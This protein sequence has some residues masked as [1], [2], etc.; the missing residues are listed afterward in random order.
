MPPS[1]FD[2]KKKSRDR[3]ERERQQSVISLSSDLAGMLQ[4]SR[5][6]AKAD[7]F[8]L[9]CQ[10]MIQDGSLQ[11]Q[12]TPEIRKSKQQRRQDEV[13]TLYC[14]THRTGSQ[15]DSSRID[16]RSPR[17]SQHIGTQTQRVSKEKAKCCRKSSKASLHIC[18]HAFS[19]SI[20]FQKK[21][22]SGRCRK[23]CWYRQSTDQSC[24][25]SPHRFRVSKP[26][27]TGQKKQTLQITQRTRAAP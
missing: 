20:P 18:V 1:T 4:F 6:N 15:K 10:Y 26:K 21:N 13:N 16:I 5:A 12:R 27:L 25:L 23:V 3:R 9:P 22:K 8:H 2:K 19:Q 7:R 11:G 17:K 24:H 14:S